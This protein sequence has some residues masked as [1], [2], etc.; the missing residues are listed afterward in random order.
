MFQ[1]RI[2]CA[3]LALLTLFGAATVS[4]QQPD[5]VKQREIM[6]RMV[7]RARNTIGKQVGEGHGSSFVEEI[8]ADAGGRP[9][10]HVTHRILENKRPIPLISCGWGQRVVKLGKGNQPLIPHAGCIV[11]FEECCFE[12]DGY[13]D[14]FVH[15]SAIVEEANGSMVTLL[16]QYAGD[17][18][19]GATVSRATIDF[20][21]QVRGHYFIYQPLP[22]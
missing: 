22:N 9:M 4:A 10:V 17:S 20:A 5:R 7:E 6:Q 1:H 21:T 15:H 18:K 8:L 3:G 2:P 12:M 11:Q 13:T 19:S 16:H 14:N